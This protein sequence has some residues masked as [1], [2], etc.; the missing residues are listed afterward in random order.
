MLF[1]AH[2]NPMLGSESSEKSRECEEATNSRHDQPANDGKNPVQ[3]PIS[4]DPAINTESNKAQSYE[5][6][7]YR[8]QKWGLVVQVCLC[9][10]TALA[11][12]AAAYYAEIARRQ[13]NT[14]NVALTEAHIQNVAQQ[15][16]VLTIDS[17]PFWL[18]QGDLAIRVRN[19][20]HMPARITVYRVRYKQITGTGAYVR[21]REVKPGSTVS[22]EDPYVISV[23]LP[24]VPQFVNGQVWDVSLDL[25]IGYDDGFGETQFVTACFNPEFTGRDFTVFNYQWQA[26]C[27]AVNSVDLSKPLPTDVVV[28]GKHSDNR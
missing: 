25:I 18:S 15:R 12:G 27:Q 17:K 19:Q 26:S 21:N 14:M 6:K 3:R 16:A 13:L 11:F 10:F 7:D 1:D 2:G 5:E 8:L 9:A 22:I 23:S 28:S 24:P 20:G 4:N